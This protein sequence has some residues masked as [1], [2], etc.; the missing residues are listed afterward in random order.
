MLSICTR[1]VSTISCGQ[2]NARAAAAI[3]SMTCSM[4]FSLF[5]AVSIRQVDIA[6]KAAL[7]ALRA[8]SERPAADIGLKA[9]G[10]TPSNLFCIAT[11]PLADHGT[12]PRASNKHTVRFPGVFYAPGYDI[13]MSTEQTNQRS[14]SRHRGSEA[15]RCQDAP[16]RLGKFRHDGS[17]LSRVRR[18]RNALIPGDEE[19][20][21]AVGPD[22]D[23]IKGIGAE[24]QHVAVVG[25]GDDAEQLDLL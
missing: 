15:P 12:Q 1:V 17:P 23:A 24:R 14:V 4:F 9:R 16:R 13:S 25:A 21:G 7:T 18:H 2:P 20:P 6:S 3:F 19:M 5:L 10:V 11:T 22:P 8:S